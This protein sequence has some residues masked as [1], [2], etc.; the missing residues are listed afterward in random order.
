MCNCN[1]VPMKMYCNC[2]GDSNVGGNTGLKETVLFNGIINTE[3][4][5]ELSDNINNYDDLYIVHEQKMGS[6]RQCLTI[7]VSCLDD[8]QMVCH[9]NGQISTYIEFNINDNTL[10]ASTI[11]DSYRIVKIVGRKY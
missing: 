4:S 6:Y 10:N 8:S 7:P 2:G 11:V 9:G 1:F 3:G 5:Y